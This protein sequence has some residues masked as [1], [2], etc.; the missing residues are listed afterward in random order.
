MSQSSDISEYPLSPAL[1][2][3]VVNYL[4]GFRL[5][6]SIILGVAFATDA[7]VQGETFADPA[8]AA[9]LLISYGITAIV[10]IIMAARPGADHYNL[11]MGSL[12]I[13]VVVI[14]VLLMTF[15]GLNSGLGVLLLFI[16][17][18][19]AILLPLREALFISSLATIAI[20]GEAAIGG[21]VNPEG[22]RHLIRSGLYGLTLFIIT[23]LAHALA[24]WVR[25][26]RLIAERQAR[27]LTRLEQI[28]ELIIRRMRGGVLAVDEAGEIRMLNESAWYLLGGPPTSERVLEE[29]SPELHA[30]LRAW[31]EDPKSEPDPITLSKSQA[32]IIPRFVTLPVGEELAALIFLEDSDVVSQRAVELSAVTLAKLSTSIAHEIRNPLSAMSHAAQLLAENEG[33]DEADARLVEIIRKQSKRMNGIVENIMQLSRREKSRTE[34]IQL[35]DW[36]GDIGAEF[37]AAHADVGFELKQGGSEDIALVMF[38]PSQLLQVVWKL[39][40]NAA[41][42]A[43]SEDAEPWIHLELHVNEPSEGYCLVSVANNGAGIPE[44]AIGDIFE[45]F[46]TTRKEGTG[47][48]LY[49]ARQLCEANQAE[50]TVDSVPGRE[51]RFQIRMAMTAGSTI[52]AGNA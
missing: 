16:S 11:A 20:I 12:L 38:D 17:A 28:N 51:T 30:E 21:F 32:E 8:F 50:L 33:L 1:T 40:E 52:P 45:P 14:S 10:L 27:T 39:L 5:F 7:L 34:A 43:G 18:A 48:G 46:F 6:I 4:N 26:F 13:D 36:L 35:R 19:A 2:H 31:S 15:G 41:Q 3:R 24:F 44:D 49:I 29:V 42:H 23:L 22:T 37:Q 9:A 25:D 47:L